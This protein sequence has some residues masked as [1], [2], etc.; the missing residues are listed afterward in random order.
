M[1]TDRNESPALAILAPVVTA[2]QRPTRYVH[3]VAVTAGGSTTEVIGF[4]E[5]IAPVGMGKKIV[6]YHTGAQ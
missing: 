6:T 5:E 3:H 2:F 1:M 4:W